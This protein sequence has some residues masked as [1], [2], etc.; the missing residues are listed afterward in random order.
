MFISDISTLK[1]I[2]V[3]SKDVVART[4]ITSGPWRITFEWEQNGE[5]FSVSRDVIIE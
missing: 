5:Q 4:D 3:N 1:I 2:D